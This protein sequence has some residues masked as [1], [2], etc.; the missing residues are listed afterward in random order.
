MTI[1]DGRMGHKHQHMIK[2]LGNNTEGGPHQTTDMEP[3]SDVKRAIPRDFPS[4]LQD[5]GQSDP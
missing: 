4:Q 2:H 1:W 5:Q 3:V